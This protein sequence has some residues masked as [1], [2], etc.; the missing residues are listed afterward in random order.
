MLKKFLLP[1]GY[2]YLLRVPLLV[3]LFILFTFFGSFPGAGGEPILRGIFDVAS[4]HY[5]TAIVSVRFAVITLAALLAGSA[6]W[7]TSRMIIAN[8][9]QRF[10]IQPVQMTLGIE[11]LVRFLPLVAVLLVLGRAA[12][13][14]GP[15]LNEGGWGKLIGLVAGSALWFALTLGVQ[16]LA[17]VITPKLPASFVGYVGVGGVVYRRQVFA[18]LQW[19]ISVLAYFLYLGLSFFDQLT[20][21]TFSLIFLLLTLL[22]WSFAGLSFFVDRY[23]IPLVFVVL[24]WGFVAGKFPQNDHFYEVF[25]RK[26]PLKEPVAGSEILQYYAGLS[27]NS[28]TVHSAP[29]TITGCKPSQNGQP[30]VLVATTGGGIQASAWTARVLAGL[31]ADIPGFDCRVAMVSSVSGGSVGAMYFVNAYKDGAIPDEIKKQP[32]NKNPIVK[33][34]ETSSLD[35]V[36]WGLAYPDLGLGL[37]PFLKGIGRG[38]EGNLHFV[39]GGFIFTDRGLT[40]ENSW[41][42]RLEGSEVQLS[43]WRK[44]VSEHKRPAVIFNSTLVETGQRFLLS[45]TDIDPPQDTSLDRTTGRVEFFDCYA[46]SD[47]KVRTAARLSAT[48]PYVSPA[49]R[50][51]RHAEQNQTRSQNKECPHTS[52]G[53]YDSQPHAVDGGYYDNYGMATL[54]DW[55]DAGFRKMD[56]PGDKTQ[57][58]KILIVEIRASPT[59]AQNTDPH[60]FG[61]IFQTLHPLETLWNVSETGQLSHNAL[62]EELIQRLYGVPNVSSVIFEFNYVDARGTPRAKPLNWHLTPEDIDALRESWCLSENQI[63]KAR[64]FFGQSGEISRKE[65]Q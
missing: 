7:F 46:D 59:K 49:T 43:G 18:S 28:S 32:L 26:A 51:L 61:F 45:T 65:C 14:S 31:A 12:I 40:L 6:I 38:S 56:K 55:L 1:L 63:K 9:Q 20:L 33:W 44:D 5:S 22:C 50:M 37:F 3:W 16:W 34:A 58:P 41:E 53:I 54:L 17:D 64:Q 35:D 42:H 19:L 57:L 4:F 13:F 23:R 48:F 27:S 15:S 11:F 8:A 52:A 47:M 21:P 29:N 10:G 62:D 39:D 36:A 24:A 2:F 30:I 25:D 60:S